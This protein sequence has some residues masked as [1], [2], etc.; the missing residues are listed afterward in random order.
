MDADELRVKIRAGQ[1][2]T[3]TALHSLV[4]SSGCP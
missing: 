4:A 3:A 1:A 2:A